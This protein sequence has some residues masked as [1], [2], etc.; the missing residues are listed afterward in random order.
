VKELLKGRSVSRRM[1][2]LD[3]PSTDG[4]ADGLPLQE[5][6]AKL[7]FVKSL[8]GPVVSP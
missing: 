5:E 6:E 4:S 2:A 1:A 3:N 7:G 8:F